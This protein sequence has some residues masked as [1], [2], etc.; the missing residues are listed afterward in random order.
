[1]NWKDFFFFSGSQ[2]AGI[3]I[4]FVLIVVGFVLKALLPVLLPVKEAVVDDPEFLAEISRFHA[5]L[6]QVDSVKYTARYGR[7]AFPRNQLSDAEREERRQGEYYNRS[8]EY[9]QV[10]NY[11]AGTLNDEATL[12]PFDPNTLDSAGLRQ[13]G[14]PPRVVTGIL[15]FRRKGGMFYTPERFSE[16][17]GLSPDL[18]QRLKPYVIIDTPRTTDIHPDELLAET[19]GPVELNS[20][21]STDLLRVKGL[22]RSLIRSVLRFRNASGGFVS[23]VQLLEIYGMTHDVYTRISDGITVDSALVKKINV[24]TA[25][26]DKLRAHPYL[27]FYQA[28]SIYEYRRRKGKLT[29]VRDLQILQDIDRETLLKMADYLSF[30]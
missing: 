19:S 6:Q 24:N 2:R 12:F 11:S 21:D 20:A 30:E 8:D 16:V 14:I 18:Y 1:M 25:S 22:N 5:S 10:R 28:K 26:I 13:L 3:V 27:D 4:L 9:R 15:R 7:N 17:Y 23:K 29:S